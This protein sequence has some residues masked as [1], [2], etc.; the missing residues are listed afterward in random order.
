M[1]PA[2][3]YVKAAAKRRNRGVIVP[4]RFTHDEVVRI[5]EDAQHD[6]IREFQS[7]G[8]V[9]EVGQ[10]TPTATEPS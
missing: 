1:K 3:D 10:F 5:V 7:C 8:C 9:V 2:A 4:F 6:L